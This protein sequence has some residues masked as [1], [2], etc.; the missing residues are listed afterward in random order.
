[1]QLGFSSLVTVLVNNSLRQFQ[2]FWGQHR[3]GI[4]VCKALIIEQGSISHALDGLSQLSNG[5]NVSGRGMSK[6]QSAINIFSPVGHLGGR[7]AM[8]LHC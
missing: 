6:Q 7:T 5:F 1:M 2:D 4:W 8:C 3:V